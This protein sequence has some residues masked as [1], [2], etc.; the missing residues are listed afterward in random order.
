MINELTE[1]GILLALRK[2]IGYC[3]G[4]YRD[5]YRFFDLTFIKPFYIPVWLMTAPSVTSSQALIDLLS[6]LFINLSIIPFLPSLV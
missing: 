2:N 3:I 5:L 4:A 1:C 6:N